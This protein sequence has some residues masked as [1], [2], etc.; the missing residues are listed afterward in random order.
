MVT[1]R[2]TSDL[3]GRIT[4]GICLPSALQKPKGGWR[5]MS[6][7]ELLTIVLTIIALVLNA[8]ALGVKVGRAMKR[9]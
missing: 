2:K 1:G 4:T 5:R 7:F 8:F 6:T 3:A 9:K